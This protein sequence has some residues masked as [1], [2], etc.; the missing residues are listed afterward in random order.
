[1]SNSFT[2]VSQLKQTN[3]NGQTTYQSLPNSFSAIQTNANG[4]SPGMIT[5]TTGGTNISLSQLAVPAL[6]RIMN[7]DATNY[8]TIGT[9]VGTTFTPF[10]ELQPGESFVFRLSRSILGGGAVLRAVG[11]AGSVNV[12]VE[13][14]DQ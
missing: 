7:T 4:P 2:V 13:A 10:M 14:F 9:Y 8:V 11:N 12:L 1:M 6:C 3:G 5:A